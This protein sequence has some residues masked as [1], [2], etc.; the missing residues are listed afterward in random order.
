MV[1]EQVEQLAIRARQLTAIGQLQAAREVW[2]TILNLLPTD[3]PERRGVE[4][5]VARIDDRLHPKPKVNWTKRLGPFG[6]LLAFLAK[7]KTVALLLLTKGKFLISIF[8]FVAFYWMLFGWWFA[9]GLAGSVLIHEMG[10][11]LAVRRFG[12][13][14]ELPMFLPGLGA[15]VK[16]QGASVDPG[17]RAQISLAG[18][19]F[20]LLSGVAAYGIFQSTH[21][22]VWLAVAQFAGWL[23]LIN[24]I[25]VAILDGGAA[26]NPLG[27]QH[28]IAILIIC[29]ALGY[30]MHESAFYFVAAG[31]AYR[32][33]KRD[34]PAEPRQ[35]IAYAFVAIAVANG[36]LSWFC[37]NQARVLFNIQGH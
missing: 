29:L 12:F 33:W 7:F 2:V 11:Y 19:L 27:K 30:V 35:G 23:N 22:P 20:G 8:F 32:L 13:R 37:M 14:A 25:P 5:E 18:P 26:M 34:F 3:A 1:S 4:R 6:V 21:A 28:R 24:L 9:V 36:F 10:H 15:Y 31:T 17:I 16:W